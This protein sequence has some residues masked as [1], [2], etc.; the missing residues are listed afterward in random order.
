[1]DRTMLKWN[2]ETGVVVGAIMA[3]G[4]FIFWLVGC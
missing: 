1:M 2:L 3:L 4:A